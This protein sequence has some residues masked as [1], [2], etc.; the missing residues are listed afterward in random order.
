MGD[1]ER[2]RGTRRGPSRIRAL[3][4]HSRP[5]PLILAANGA[6]AQRAYGLL[7]VVLDVFFDSQAYLNAAAGA[8]VLSSAAMAVGRASGRWRRLGYC[9]SPV[10][11]TSSPRRWRDGLA[12]SW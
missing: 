2:L 1:R 7:T 8:F 12:P 9:H 4:S 5:C 3:G 11:S 6:K 10:R